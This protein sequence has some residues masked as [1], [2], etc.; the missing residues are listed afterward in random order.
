MALHI[1]IGYDGNRNSAKPFPVYVGESRSE[2]E[3]ARAASPAARF[4]VFSN[5]HGVRK[6]GR[7]AAAPE[8]NSTPSRGNGPDGAEVADPTPPSAPS[9]PPVAGRRKH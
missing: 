3:A 8:Q 9:P 2:A 6:A 5:V 4:E 1:V 7:P